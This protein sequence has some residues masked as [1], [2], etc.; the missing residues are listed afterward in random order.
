MF[1]A[2]ARGTSLLPFRPPRPRCHPANAFPR[3]RPHKSRVFCSAGQSAAPRNVPNQPV[4]ASE[5]RRAE[6]RRTRPGSWVTHPERPP[7]PLHAPHC[8]LFPAPAAPRPHT[9]RRARKHPRP[10]R[11][12]VRHAGGGAPIR[13]MA[14][15]E[16]GLAPTRPTRPKAPVRPLQ[17]PLLNS[18][19]SETP[20]QNA[21]Y[22][23]FSFPKRRAPA[24]PPT[25]HRA[26]SGSRRS[27]PGTA[28]PTPPAPCP[29]APSPAAPRPVSPRT[30]RSR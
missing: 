28:P 14:S 6:E 13:P 5:G 12:A 4:R 23:P 11:Q 15:I 25:G 30:A 29:P 18:H 21:S 26:S 3:P 17:R 16:S 7:A 27:A 10:A 9:A 19:D 20:P 2:P 24:R 22:L 1:T 8:N